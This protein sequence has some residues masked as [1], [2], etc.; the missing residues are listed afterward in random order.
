MKKF[1]ETQPAVGT[2]V[3]IHLASGGTLTGIWD[4]LQWWAGVDGQPDD[5]PV[6]N[7]FVVGWDDL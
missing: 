6:T 4:G 5:V 1:P 7:E 3:Q 2:Q